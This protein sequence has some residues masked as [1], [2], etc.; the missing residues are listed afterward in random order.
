MIIQ[1]YINAD[2][3]FFLSFSLLLISRFPTNKSREKPANSYCAL[4]CFNEWMKM[5][6]KQIL[7]GGEDAKLAQERRISENLLAI[8]RLH[9]RQAG[10]CIA[11]WIMVIIAYSLVYICMYVWNELHRNEILYSFNAYVRRFSSIQRKFSRRRRRKNVQFT[12]KI[13]LGSRVLSLFSFFF[14]LHTHFFRD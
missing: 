13:P 11:F 10:S 12:E 5:E 3:L 2:C 9:K 1:V 7:Y 6:K 8:S 4:I 14:F